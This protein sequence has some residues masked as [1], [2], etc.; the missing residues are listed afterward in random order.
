MILCTLEIG[1]KL[2]HGVS[3]NEVLEHLAEEREW[4]AKD[5]KQ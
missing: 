4:H 2:A 5:S 1:Y 3:E